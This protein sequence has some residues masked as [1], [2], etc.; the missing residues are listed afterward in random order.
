MNN[1][2]T[3]IQNSVIKIETKKF[4]ELT[5]FEKIIRVFEIFD[6]NKEEIPLILKW[7][8]IN[9]YDLFVN[10]ESFKKK[11][12]P[13]LI[14]FLSKNFKINLQAFYGNDRELIKINTIGFYKNVKNFSDNI[15][16]ILKSED[17]YLYILSES[18]PCKEN[19]EENNFI[20]LIKRPLFNVPE[21][22]K[23]VYTFD[24]Y[25]DGCWWG[26]WKCRYNLKSLLIYL[27]K[28]HQ[29]HFSKI[30]GYSM[31]DGLIGNMYSFSEGNLPIKEFFNPMRASIWYPED[32]IEFPSENINARESDEL[33]LV[34]D[35][36]NKGKWVWY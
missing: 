15:A 10:E 13:D 9:F 3:K 30:T 11:V 22:Q 35:E 20:L 33:Q 24:I 4:N 26:Y 16:S 36:I 28:K 7:F 23:Q 2:N 34:L 8:D 32:Y 12:S 27:R 6:I 19:E 1:D 17:S 25:H 21:T 31:G 5:I 14:R 29:V 18:I